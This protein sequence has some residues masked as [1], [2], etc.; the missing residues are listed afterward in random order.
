[1]DRSSW[2]ILTK[3]EPLKQKQQPTPV[4]FPGEPHGQY[5]KTKKKDMTTEH[6][7]FRLEGVHYSTGEEQRDITNSSSKNEAAGPQQE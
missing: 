4:L 2:R 6:E 7:P 3:N 1:M 5:E